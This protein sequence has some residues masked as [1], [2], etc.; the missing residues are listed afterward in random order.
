MGVSASMGWYSFIYSVNWTA[1]FRSES[2][3]WVLWWVE[4]Y[5]GKR[6]EFAMA[7]DF[8]ITLLRQ[9]MVILEFHTVSF[10]RNVIVPGFK[11]LTF[12]SKKAKDFSDW[13]LCVEVYFTGHHTLQEWENG[14]LRFKSRIN[15]NRLSTNPNNQRELIIPQTEVDA[16]F[17]LSVW[18]DPTGWTGGV[19]VGTIFLIVA[20]FRLIN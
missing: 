15:N 5:E 9:P 11:A 7:L 3:Y 2:H 18:P 10:L 16:V 19:L 8:H 17:S 4:T 13:S 6:V 20:L 12:L 14:I 1:G